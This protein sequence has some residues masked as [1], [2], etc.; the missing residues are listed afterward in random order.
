MTVYAEILRDLRHV[1][2][3]IDGLLSLVRR[4]PGGD[5]IKAFHGN[6]TGGRTAAGILN[7]REGA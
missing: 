4:V 6:G 7:K 2:R 1:R 3:E 5:S